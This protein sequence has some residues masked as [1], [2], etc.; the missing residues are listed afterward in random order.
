MLALAL[1]AT[2][3]A[4]SAARAQ[5]LVYVIRHAERADDPARDQQDPALSAA[6]EKRAARLAVLL[7]DAGIRAIYVTEFR[8]TQQTAAPLASKLRITP[9]VTPAS[10]SGLIADLKAKH[11]DDVVLLV[12]HS[13]TMPALIR[14][15]GGPVVAVDDSDY[16]SV[17]VVV[18]S[19]G[20]VSRLRF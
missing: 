17:F 12:A 1:L 10:T 16:D 19:I 9:D 8:R 2:L 13:S 18:P 4:P 3:V 7:A 15:L 5:K 20:A 11:K 6:G 14:G